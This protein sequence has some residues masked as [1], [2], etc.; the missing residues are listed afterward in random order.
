MPSSPARPETVV[1]PFRHLV[2]DYEHSDRELLMSHLCAYRLAATL[3]RGR[4][5]LEVGSGSGY[6]AY[7]LAHVAAQ[8]IAVDMDPVCVKLAQEL[9]QRPNLD[10][11]VM[12]ARSL[13]WPD[14]TFDVIGTFQV[15]EHI[16]ESHLLDFVRGLARLLTP[17]GVL[18]VSTL[19]LEHNRKPGR[20][21]EKPSFHEKEFTEGELRALL[22]EVFPVVEM[23][24]LYPGARHRLMRRLKKWGIDRLGPAAVNPVRRFYEA[25]LDTDDHCLKP[26]CSPQAIDLIACCAM[27][28]RMFPAMWDAA[29]G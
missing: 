2:R 6:G 4:R 25:G 18:V 3:G 23:R 27:R 19:N 8:V 28:E 20:P 1:E 21:Y 15:I 14:G 11:R 17:D 26:A 7:Y 16:P 22:A 24:G 10:Y 13:E 29:H 5:M 9:F 12:D